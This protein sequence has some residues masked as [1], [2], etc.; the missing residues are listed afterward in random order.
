M[1]VLRTPDEYF[2]DLD[3]F[4]FEPH[5]AQSTGGIRIHYLDEG[6]RS[7]PV[8]LLMHG[9]PSWCYLYRKMIPTLVSHGIRCV[10]PDL[11]GFGR[12]DKPTRSADYSY[13][14]HVEWMASLV[15]GALALEDVT[16]YCQDWGGLIGLRLVGEKPNIF[17]R[18]V[19][20]N[21]G[22]P[23]GDHPPT[24]AFLSWQ[25]YS[26][27]SP[28][29]P[30]G[31][32][33]SR[34]CK[35]PLAQSVVRAYDA[36]FPDDSYKVGARVFPALVPTSTEDPARKANLAAWE[37]LERFERPF[38]CAFSDSDPITRGWERAFLGRIP[39]TKS[40]P[41]RTIEGAGHFLQED[42]GP[43]IAEFLV[44]LIAQRG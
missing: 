25:R 12:S 6:P 1:E 18:V 44:E 23:T 13:Q 24:E 28:E 4:D 2:E 35:T 33:V 27:E 38:V 21:T 9:E 32:I 16:L 36:P 10:A 30:V 15:F 11:V 5:Y 31:A 39:G 20:S 3:G 43:A 42:Q 34:G 7:G 8:A 19:V 41:H 29:L 14:N 40:Q 26:Q 37:V 17:S 22:L